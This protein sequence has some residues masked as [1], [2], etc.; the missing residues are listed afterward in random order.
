[1]NKILMTCCLV[2]LLS[3]PTFSIAD[4]DTLFDKLDKNKDGVLS[5]E[6]IAGG[7]LVVVKRKD[8]ARQLQHKEL[9]EQGEIAAINEEQNRRLFEHVDQN[10]DGYINRKEW[11]RASPD[12]FVLWRF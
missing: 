2:L 8:G 12:G 11:S 5:K 4:D 1:M 9:I 7:D 10:K 6:E 3:S